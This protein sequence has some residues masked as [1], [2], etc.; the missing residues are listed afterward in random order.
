MRLALTGTSPEPF[1]RSCF[2]VGQRSTIDD[3]GA[4]E[5]GATIVNPD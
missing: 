4:F 2:M 5:T 3:Y 1:D